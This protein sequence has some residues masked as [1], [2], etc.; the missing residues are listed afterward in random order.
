M[1]KR[2][3]C[4]YLGLVAIALPQSGFAAPT[5]LNGLKA[6]V[7]GEPITQVDLNEAVRTQV[8]MYLMKNK[9]MVSA[10]QA[11]RDIR[12]MEENALNDLIDRKLILSEFKT[13]G[14]EIQPKYID[15][16]VDRF[17]KGRFGGDRDKF[18]KQL[19][20]QG[21]TLNQ[22]R[23]VQRDQIAVQA[24]QGRH[25]SRPGSN[26]SLPHERREVYNEIKNEFAS[27][28]KLK[29]RML[30]IP[31]VTQFNSASEQEALIKSVRTK[32]LK[33]SSFSS[34]AKEH[35]KDSFAS[36]GGYVGEIG[37]STLN[38]RLTQIAYSLPSG[39][40]SEVI[41]DGP[42]WRLMY[43]DGRTGQKVPSQKEIEDEVEK[44]LA[45]K[46]RQANMDS[47]LKKLRRDANVRIF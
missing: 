25:S 5:E 32:I 12:K 21:I 31:K 47:W 42:S 20:E 36:K 13:M 4:I 26:F 28:G 15:E 16:A 18:L 34:M 46:K 29:L 11:E 37:R 1:K 30:S 38:A 45:V 9:G 22:F 14:G 39:K 41:D 35:S 27:E 33:G 10:S 7:N 3:F 6:V 44:R 23:E 43:V 8:Q 2:L 19:S 17:V 40:V 24:L